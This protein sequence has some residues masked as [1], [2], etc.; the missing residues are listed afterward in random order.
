MTD[1]W[2]TCG[3]REGEAVRTPVGDGVIAQATG[4]DR[5]LVK[6]RTGQPAWFHKRVLSKTSPPE[7][8]E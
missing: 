5:V 4:G 3:W 1:D 6:L 7:T 8:E 2:K